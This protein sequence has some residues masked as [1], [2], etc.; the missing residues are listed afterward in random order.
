MHEMVDFTVYNMDVSGD[1]YTYYCGIEECMPAHSYGPAVRDHYL[2]HFVLEGKGRFEVDG[3]VYPLEK[4]QAFL[5]VPDVTTYYE[6]SAEDPWHYAWI[7]FNGLKARQHLD[8]IGISRSSPVFPGEGISAAPDTYNLLKKCLADTIRV[9]ACNNRSRDMKL[10]SLLYEFMSI[11]MEAGVSAPP[12]G[13]PGSFQDLY[14]DT[15]VSYVAK[16]YSRKTSISEL[17]GYVGID[18]S[19]LYELFVK[20]FQMSPRE[21]LVNFRMHKACELLLQTNL[22]VGAVSNSVGYED[23]LAFSKIFKKAVGKSPLKY[24]REKEFN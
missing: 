8:R 18:R 7:G 2:L 10:Q 1:L 23:Q 3:K 5:I 12:A 4:G 19:Y 13:R 9:S 15:A 24:K 16:N 6:A 14:V 22:T 17:A 21:F 20:R 11:L